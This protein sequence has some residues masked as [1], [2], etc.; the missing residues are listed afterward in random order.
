MDSTRNTNEIIQPYTDFAS[1]LHNP[2]GYP[3]EE[4]KAAI[5]V[6]KRH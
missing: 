5:I 2:W 3:T 4:E 1:F 6:F